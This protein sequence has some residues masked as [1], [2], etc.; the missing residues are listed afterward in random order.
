MLSPKFPEF[1][2]IVRPHV[3]ED[4]AFYCSALNGLDNVK[5]LKEGTSAPWLSGAD[6]LIHNGSSVG[7]EAYFQQKSVIHYEFSS[8][9]NEETD[10]LIVKK[11]GSTCN[12]P[13]EVIKVINDVVQGKKL[14]NSE[15]GILNFGQ[16]G[17]GPLIQ[18]ATLR[19]YLPVKNVKKPTDKVTINTKII[20]IFFL[21]KSIIM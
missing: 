1:Q 8:S 18:Y 16:D 3:A 4:K 21:I 2:I 7:L 13:P 17:S 15:N 19:E 20:N 10:S 5:V 6:L 9:S 11:I 12:N 14:D